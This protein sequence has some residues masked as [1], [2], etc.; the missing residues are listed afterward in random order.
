MTETVCSKK[1]IITGSAGF[2]GFHLADLMLD[3]GWSVIGVDALTDYYDVDLKRHRHEILKRNTCFRE[4]IGNLEDGEFVD[5]LLLRE[6]A[7]VVV[8]LAAQAGVRYSIDNPASYVQGNLIATFNILEAARQTKPD[9]LLMA[10]TSSGYGSNREMPYKENQRTDTQLSF[11]AATKKSCEVMSHSY[12]HL[13]GIP[14]TCFRFFTVYG[15]WGRPDMALFKFTEAMLSDSEIEVYNDGDMSR[16]FTYVSDLVRAISLLI[17]C[18]P[19]ADKSEADSGVAA[20]WRV[21]NVGNSKPERLMDLISALELSL[22][23][24]AKKAF[25][26]MQPGDVKDT[27]ADSSLLFELTGY[28][29]QTPIQEGVDKF[30]KWYRSYYS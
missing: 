26:P 28:Q 30:V 22:G 23:I 7:D 10:S 15:P 16:D 5:S 29:P 19:K 9:H 6:K 17:P 20:P 21:V 3:N 2:I 27:W 12:A 1:I 11:Y 13:F 18:A 25:L 24:I 14:T 4:V 8:H